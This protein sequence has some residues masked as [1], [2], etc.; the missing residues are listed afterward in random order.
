MSDFCQFGSRHHQF[1]LG[2][3]AHTRLLPL[4]RRLGKHLLRPH[5]SPDRTSCPL[6]VRSGTCAAHK[7]MSAWLPTKSDFVRLIDHFIGCDDQRGWKTD[8]NRLRR[9][10]VD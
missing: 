5:R 10:A 3:L 6:W 8:A 4:T 7:L 9:L 2:F 1:E